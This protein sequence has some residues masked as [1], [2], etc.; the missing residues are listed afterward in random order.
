MNQDHFVKWLAGRLNPDKKNTRKS[1]INKKILQQN[2]EPFVGEEQLKYNSFKLVSLNKN[3]L[4]MGWGKNQ[5]HVK[6]CK[7]KT[8]NHSGDS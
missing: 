5:N 3:N 8:R 7:T 1:Y 2:L 4:G 6:P